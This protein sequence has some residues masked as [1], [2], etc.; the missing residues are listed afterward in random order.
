MKFQLTGWKAVAFLILAGVF[1]IGKNMWTQSDTQGAIEAIKPWLKG[2]Y[3][4]YYLDRMRSN[5]MSMEEGG[6]RIVETGENLDVKV[7]AM[8]G[9]AR[10]VVCVKISVAGEK[11]PV[12]KDERCF[13]M[14]HSALIGWSYD[15]ETDSV[16]YYLEML[17]PW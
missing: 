9:S 16:G 2:E 7:T 13:R 11:P 12:G 6:A 15:R 4:R 1:I 17:K 14:R 5:A 8:T 10:P 3:S